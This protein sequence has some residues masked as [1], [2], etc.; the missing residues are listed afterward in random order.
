MT[1]DLER[2]ARLKKSLARLVTLARAI[3]RKPDLRLTVAGAQNKVTL[4]MEARHVAGT[5][6]AVKTMLDHETAPRITTRRERAQTALRPSIPPSVEPARPGRP[7]RTGLV[8][9][10][11]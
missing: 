1:L 3:R 6:R 9:M 2:I 4:G 7:P 11:D 5:A 8:T 10:R